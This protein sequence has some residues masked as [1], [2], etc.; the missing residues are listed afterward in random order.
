MVRELLLDKLPNIGLK[1][2]NPG[3]LVGGNEGGVLRNRRALQRTGRAWRFLEG[4]C[5]EESSKRRVGSCAGFAAVR[6]RSIC[7][8]SLTSA[9]RQRECSG[10][11]QRRDTNS[12]SQPS[13][14]HRP[15]LVRPH[16]MVNPQQAS[17]VAA[18]DGT[19]KTRVVMEA[20]KRPATSRE[21]SE[22]MWFSLVRALFSQPCWPCVAC[23]ERS[24]PWIA[25]AGPKAPWSPCSI[26][27]GFHCFAQHAVDRL[28]LLP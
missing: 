25:T 1:P 27:A 20:A 14:L 26:P 12:K 5:G 23:R 17:S 11:Y 22:R 24:L 13:S 19:G 16:T 8:R 2:R 7:T 3:Q 10:D 21:F 18:K 15:L 4:H 6:W 28:S 9:I